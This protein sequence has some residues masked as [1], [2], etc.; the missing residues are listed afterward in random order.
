MA[1]G[2]QDHHQLLSQE[3]QGKKSLL[4]II[5]AGELHVS[6]SDKGKGLVVMALDMYHQMS[7]VHTEGDREVG[8]RELEESQREI[9]AHARALARIVNLGAEGGNRN[10]ARCFDNVSSHACDPPVL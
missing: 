7:V 2:S 4:K 8:W 3:M 10:Q 9:R 6:P 1:G 5:T